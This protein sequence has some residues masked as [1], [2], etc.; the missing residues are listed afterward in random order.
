MWHML[1]WPIPQTEPQPLR[2]AGGWRCRHRHQIFLAGAIRFRP[3]Q[4]LVPYTN[5]AMYIGHVNPGVGYCWTQTN[6]VWCL[7]VP[8]R[9]VLNAFWPAFIV[10]IVILGGL[11][12]LGVPRLIDGIISFDRRRCLENDSDV[13]HG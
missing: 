6:G 3:M 7:C 5:A 8:A 2:R 13:G 11:A 9:P 12:L 4:T 10:C 1:E